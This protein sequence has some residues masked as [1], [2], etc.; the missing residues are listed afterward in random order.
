MTDQIEYLLWLWRKLDRTTTWLIVQMRST[1]KL[2]WSCCDRPIYDKNQARQR[3]DL[4]YRSCLRWNQ[5]RT[6]ETY[7]TTC[8]LWWQQDKTTMWPIIQV[9]SMSKMILNC[10]D[11]LDRVQSMTNT[12]LNCQDRSN[13]VATVTK[14][15]Q[16]NDVTNL[17]GSIHVENDTELLWP[18]KLG[19]NYD[20]KQIEKLCDWSYRCGLCQKWYLII[21]TDRIECWLW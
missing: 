20:E 10:C 9:C 5:N 1:L 13:R 6:V 8:Y 4:S 21:V 12:I 14:T 2:K 7:L 16:H 18:I 11:W 15:R 3:R 17:I 19:V